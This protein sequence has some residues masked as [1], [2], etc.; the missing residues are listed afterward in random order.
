MKKEN[1]IEEVIPAGEVN[2]EF[3]RSDPICI[4]VVVTK[5]IVSVKHR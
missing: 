3:N 2:V 5:N 4:E 1:P